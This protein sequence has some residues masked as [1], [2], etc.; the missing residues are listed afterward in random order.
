MGNFKKYLESKDM[1]TSTI[2]F[3]YNNLIQFIRWTETENLESEQCTYNELLDY[4]R[5]LRKKQVKPSTVQKQVKTLEHYY[6]WLISEEARQD[7][8]AMNISIRGIKRKHLY[9]IINRKELETLYHNYVIPPEES[10]DKNQNWYKRTLLAARRNK[11]IIG[12][13][14]FQGLSTHDLKKIT[15]DHVKLRQG[16]IHI[17]SGRKRNERDLTL[18]PHQV[19]DLMEYITITRNEILS[20][21]GEQSDNLIVSTRA[22]TKTGKKINHIMENL[23]INIKKQNPDI[24]DLMQIRASVITYWLKLHNLRQVQHMA[25]HRYISSTERYLINDIEDLQEEIEKYHPINE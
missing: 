3:Y 4:I 9:N 18:E 17:P 8:P 13:M 25:G 21:T 15:T 12:L 10:P 1:S 19:L 23:I 20:L 11:I 5:H 14:V 22:A 16:K 6:N 7:N 2:E 24:T